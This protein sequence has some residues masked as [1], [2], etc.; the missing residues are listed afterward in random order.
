MSKIVVPFHLINLN[1]P[2]GNVENNSKKFYLRLGWLKLYDGSE[3]DV[4]LDRPLDNFTPISGTIT[5]ADTV[6]TAL[7]KMQYAFSALNLQLVTDFGNTTTNDIILNNTPGKYGTYTAQNTI[8]DIGSFYTLFDASNESYTSYYAAYGFG[9]N[10]S[11][12]TLSKSLSFSESS[13]TIQSTDTS[14][15]NYTGLLIF[16]ATDLNGSPYIFMTNKSD[17]YGQL[18]ISNLTNNVTLQ[19]PNKNSGTYTIA[20]TDDIGTSVWGSITGTITSQTD[21]ISYLST[22]YFPI[23]TGTTS[24]YIRGNGTLATFPTIPTV[25]TWGALDYPAWTTGTPFVKMT[26]AGTFALDTNT[27]VT[28][29]ALSTYVPYTGATTNVNLGT[30]SLTA[31]TLTI[32]DN[33]SGITTGSINLTGTFPHIVIGSTG[34]EG[35]IR[36]NG[37]GLYLGGPQPIINFVT[38]PTYTSN[39]WAE[40]NKHNGI[41]YLNTTFNINTTSNLGYTLGVNG[42]IFGNSFI[43]SGG[44]SSQYLMA[45]GS[46]TTG[47]SYSLPIAS[48]SVLGG[49]KVNGGGVSIAGDGTISVSTNYQAPLSGTGILK[50][51]GTNPSYISGTSSQFVKGDGSL[52]SNSYI[53]SP[54]TTKGDIFVRSTVDTKLPIGT[55]GQYLISDSNQST[56]LKWQTLSLSGYVP[57]SSYGTNNVSANNFFNGFTSVVASGTLITLTVNSTPYYLVTNTGGYTGGQVIKLPDATTLP[58]GTSYIFNNNQSQGAIT[59]NNNSNTLV[60]SIP[61]G[62]NVIIEL[63]DNTSAAGLWDSHSQAPSNVSWSTNTFNYGGSFTGG[64]WN[65]NPIGILYGGT[66]SSTQNFVDLTTN[67]TIAGAKTFS[68]A[69]ILSSLTASQILALDASKNIQSLD[70]ATYPSLSEL[71][72][73]K[74]VTS[75]IQT[76]L[77]GKQA[78][79]TYV[80]G[81]GTTGQIAY[82]PSNGSAISGLDTATYPSITELSYVKGV[83]SAI[84]T[85][86]NGKQASLGYTPPRSFFSGIDGTTVTNTTTITATYSQLIPANTFA[87][88]DVVK[89][90]FR[91][92]NASAKTAISNIY[93]YQ[94][95]ANSLSSPSPNQLGTYATAITGRTVQMERTLAIKGSTSKV[96]TSS[97]SVPSD[98]I[99]SN[100]M[101][102]YTI[103]WT[104]NQYII[105]AIGHTLAAA[106]ETLAG[107]FFRITKS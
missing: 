62:G 88:G 7:E 23:P 78:A 21:L 11:Y 45:D 47:S 87:A 35:H 48:S 61:S 64:T 15:P 38:Y 65:G 55:D 19:F 97:A 71:A 31:K 76:Q 6:L 80:T 43:K 68:T 101:T 1:N 46:V 107:D 37:L 41:S 27:Y 98:V 85:Q 96:I 72:T 49:V 52:D 26:A 67:Q 92:S 51:S 18:K 82:F 83:T 58:N 16:E 36:T 4:V 95:T 32:T 54:L 34:G 93:I 8:E 104:V 103:D 94:N 42:T 81:G 13:L 12:N 5:S 86:L 29:S 63:I 60:K 90:E 39:K 50:F 24:Q 30:N 3:S 28:L 100:A 57:Y 56:G 25:G 14:N 89:I 77:N 79:G 84:Q 59:V 66:G 9:L 17:S 75:S 10:A 20:T 69:P 74:G 44:T 91:V 53:T 73:V 40:F 102:T 106:G 105:F 22:N 33:P 2:S 70:V 99:Q